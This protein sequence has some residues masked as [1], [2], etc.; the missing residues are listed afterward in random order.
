MNGRRRIGGVAL[1]AVLWM[2]AALGLAAHSLIGSLRGEIRHIGDERAQLAAGAVADG[3]I[4][5]ALQ[6][7]QVN[8]LTSVNQIRP[9]RLRYQD[10]DV[11]IEVIPLNGWIDINNAPE[12]L[13]QALFQHGGG[14]P[15]AQAQQLAQAAK[16]FR[17]QRGPQGRAQGFEAPEDLL[18]VPGLDFDLYVKIERLVTA[19]LSSGGRV[20]P[21][22][23]PEPVL[24]VLAGGN[25]ALAGRIAASRSMAAATT[26]LTGLSPEHVDSAGSSRVCVCAKVAL[27]DGR[28]LH[29]GWRVVLGASTV[30]GLPWRILGREQR[31]VAASSVL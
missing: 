21:L 8:R 5:L 15:A 2:V 11:D 19:E 4:L 18:R 25:T 17:E 20:N 12:S 6:D 3:A 13:L 16:V 28:V 1:I 23:A 31:L 9:Y 14:A 24:Q 30:S 29:R 10:S 27:P 26:D 22:A 7:L